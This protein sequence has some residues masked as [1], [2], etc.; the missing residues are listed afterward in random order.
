MAPTIAYCLFFNIGAIILRPDNYNKTIKPSLWRGERGSG[1][2][3]KCWFYAGWHQPLK[4]LAFLMSFVWN[5]SAIQQ[6]VPGPQ[7]F[8]F[9]SILFPNLLRCLALLNKYEIIF[10][11]DGLS[12]A[13][14]RDNFHYH[15][16]YLFML[17]LKKLFLCRHANFLAQQEGKKIRHLNFTK[18]NVDNE[19]VPLRYQP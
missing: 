6:K 19:T 17:R 14:D 16:V 2:S 5:F 11:L 3:G 4:F 15:L 8:N 9:S 7:K 1:A 18:K 13:L 12:Y 10:I